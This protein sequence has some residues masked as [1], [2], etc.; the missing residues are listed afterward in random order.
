MK[1]QQLN[2]YSYSCGGGMSGGYISTKVKRT[3][4]G[5][6]II[7]TNREWHNAI[8]ACNEYLVDA[9]IL[10]EIQTIFY[11]HHMKIWHG[12]KFTNMFVCDGC[13]YSYS[14]SLEKDNIHFSSQI[15][16]PKY[17]NKL[18]QFDEVINS[19]LDNAKKLPGLTITEVEST[20]DFLVA[21]KLTLSVYSYAD[22]CINYIIANGTDSEIT[23]SSG[24]CLTNLNTDEAIDI[25]CYSLSDEHSISAEYSEDLSGRLKK[26]L[27]AGKYRLTI[28]ELDCE[29]ELK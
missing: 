15:Y 2:Q 22:R 21:G 18:K 23:F 13:S 27:A 4:E 5:A 25:E 20:A 10:D 1:K 29:F 16:P 17:S 28:G 11:K 12:K 9:S 19:Y 24:Y 3:D 7:K 6:L 26:S 14:F 8:P